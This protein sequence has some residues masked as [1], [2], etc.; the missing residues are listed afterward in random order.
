MNKK[1]NA[2]ATFENDLLHG[3]YTTY[4]TNGKV[5]SKM[6]YEKGI[7]VSNQQEFDT[8]GNLIAEKILSEQ[9]N[10]FINL[11]KNIILF[12][13]FPSLSDGYGKSQNGY[14]PKSYV[15]AF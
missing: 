2:S 14:G 13:I 5:A 11:K 6:T 15:N 7:I 8:E 3:E 1:L 12:V 10:T 9:K 4:H